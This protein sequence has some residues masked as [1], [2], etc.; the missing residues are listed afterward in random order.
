[1]IPRRYSL[2]LFLSL[3][4]PFSGR[5]E[6][7]SD[8]DSEFLRVDTLRLPDERLISLGVGNGTPVSIN[9]QIHPD[10]AWAGWQIV[11]GAG[12]FKDVRGLISHDKQLS[13]FALGRDGQVWLNR[14]TGSEND[15]T[16]WKPIG[17]VVGFTRIFPISTTDGK[18]T[19]F[20]IGDGLVWM[21][22]QPSLNDRWAGWKRLPGVSEIGHVHSTARPDGRLNIY[23]ISL[24]SGSWLNQ[25]TATGDWG[26]WEPNPE[27]PPF[28]RR[29]TREG[30][31]MFYDAGTGSLRI[32]RWA[33]T[34]SAFSMLP[35]NGLSKGYSL[36]S[37]GHH[38]VAVDVNG[39]GRTDNVVAYQYPDK[40]MRLHVF[41][42]GGTYQGPRGW[43]QHDA[44][45]TSKVGGRM[46]GGDFNG[47][48]NGDIAMF[49][50]TGNGLNVFRFL[51]TGS[52][53]VSDTTKL[54]GYDLAKVG[55]HIAASDANGDGRTDV[56]AAFQ[57][58]NGAI[59][60]H[61]FTGGNSF[62]GQTGWWHGNS[63]DLAKVGGRMVGGD[64]D[65]N[66][67]GDIAMF[68]DTGNG[69]T[70][71]RFLSTGKSF[72]ADTKNIPGYSLARVGSRLAAGDV[73]GDG[74]TDAVTACQ[75]ENGILRLDVF[76][77]GNSDVS[78]E[79][80][81]ENEQIDPNL[82][83]GRFTMGQWQTE[84]SMAS[85]QHASK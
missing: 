9:R 54:D 11:P 53:F 13:V 70:I 67:K 81:Y 33:S 43:F 76:L 1:M 60:L 30:P 74:A 55:P 34:G 32:Y 63:H 56:V 46:V 38:M 62:A 25:Q 51:S 83:E 14:Q 12:R 28:H 40:I 26:Q 61:V 7:T 52:S 15:W 82:A 80:W 8:L 5:A 57:E 45:E 85:P 10:G 48:G 71:H 77:N 39:D 21:N 65:G 2:L 50:D 36:S 49:Y 19:C 27:L 78:R 42:N 31:A 59:R 72:T 73:N 37:I 4:L 3:L 44:F 64:F 35:T 17:A 18:L 16:Q 41:L 84:A 20:A 6:E 66:G 24:H 75:D 69:G 47:D 68:Y 22:T 58:T 79:G 23:A 29:K